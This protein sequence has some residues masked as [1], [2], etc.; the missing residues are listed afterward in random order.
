MFHFQQAQLGHGDQ[1]VFS[2]LTLTIGQGERVALLGPSGA[3]KSTLLDALRNQQESA[4]AWCPQAGALV[5]MLSVFHNIYMGA[6]SR[7]GT[8]TNLR[9]LIAPSRHEREQIG[10][11]ATDLSLHNKLFTSIDQLSGGQAQRAALG[12]ALYTQRPILLADEPVSSLDE[13]QG[14]AL[15]TLSLARHD[16]AV[17]ALHDRALA[18]ACSDRIIGLNH[19]KVVLDAATHSLSLSDLDALYQDASYQ[20]RSYQ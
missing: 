15:L 20:H 14:L 18:L 10:A 7:N 3:G 8:L 1:V 5:P 6:L 4:C 2:D 9:N 19:G 12:R 16:S 17:I 11:L 13:H